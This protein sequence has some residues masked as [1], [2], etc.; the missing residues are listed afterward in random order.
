MDEPDPRVI[1]RARSGDEV[2]F[3]QLVRA[4]QAPVWRFVRHLLA[5]AALAEDVTQETFVRV[6]RHLAR[7]R[8]DA[9][10]STWVFAIARNAALDAAR[11]RAR[12]ERLHDAAGA[13]GATPS[14]E[15][16]HELAAALAALPADLREALLVV[17]VLGLRYDEAG[18]VLGVPAGTVKSRVH[19]ARAHLAAWLAADDGE[20]AGGV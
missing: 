17:E 12:R 4:Y 19:R 1:E 11:S 13:A 2:A 6:H 7:F 8:R 3:A 10:F 16:G 14:P 5:D 9:R 20:A 15:G 18:P